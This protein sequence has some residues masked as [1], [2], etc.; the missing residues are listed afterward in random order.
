[1]GL[2]TTRVLLREL[3]RPGLRGPATGPTVLSSFCSVRCG[4]QVEADVKIEIGDDVR[5]FTV[6]DNCAICEQAGVRDSVLA[7]ADSV[8]VCDQP[9]YAVARGAA[10]KLRAR[11]VGNDVP[12]AVERIAPEL[13]LTIERGYFDHDGMLNGTTIEVPTGHAGAERFV[14]AHEIGHHELRHDGSREKIEPEA[15]AFASE[16]IIPRARLRV[17]ITSMPYL[18][19]LAGRFEVRRQAIFYAVSSARLTSKLLG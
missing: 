14:I 8:S 2:E 7:P 18:T 6:D 12:V 3:R 11:T 17:E 4:W 10:Q 13:G 19:Q 15:N 1:V 16:L 9:E 5:T